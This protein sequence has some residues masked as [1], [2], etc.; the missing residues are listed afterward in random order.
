MNPSGWTSGD[1]PTTRRALASGDAE[2]FAR[3]HVSYTSS[4]GLVLVR[5]GQLD[6]AIAVTSDAVQR[7]ATVRGSGRIL[8]RLNHTVDLLG[9]QNYPPA[10]TFANLAHRLLPA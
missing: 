4:L 1:Q 5:R 6:E 8:G 2:T 10:K 7:I 9:Q 3:N